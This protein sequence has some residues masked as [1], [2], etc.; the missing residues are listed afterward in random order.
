MANCPIRKTGNQS[1]AKLEGKIFQYNA[2]CIFDNDISISYL[3][4]LRLFV[5]KVQLKNDTIKKKDYSI[6]MELMH[7]AEPPQNIKVHHMYSLPYESHLGKVFF[8][9]SACLI[10]IP[11]CDERIRFRYLGEASR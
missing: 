9:V 3:G 6:L 7:L 5:F 2:L 11:T 8:V 10:P 1:L 4:S